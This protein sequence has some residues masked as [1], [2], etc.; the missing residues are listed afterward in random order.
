MRQPVLLQ[1]IVE[2]TMID[3]IKEKFN[4]CV[5]RSC[6]YQI[7]NHISYRTKD[8]PLHKIICKIAYS[9]IYSFL[10]GSILKIQ[11]AL[12]DTARIPTRINVIDRII[13][14]IR[15]PIQL[16]RVL[17]IIRPFIT[18]AKASDTW[19]ILYNLGTLAVET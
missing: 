14:Y 4:K 5:F 3:R 17:I 1:K 6:T 11:T 9:R 19:V 16:Y 2:P 13:V 7:T 8:H 10:Y 18:T 15:I 12:P